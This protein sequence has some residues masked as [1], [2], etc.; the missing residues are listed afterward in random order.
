MAAVAGQQEQ[1]TVEQFSGPAERDHAL[2]EDTSRLL[3]T[4]D[5]AYEGVQG[6]QGVHGLQAIAGL[7]GFEEFQGLTS[8]GP[9]ALARLA[10]RGIRVRAL[11]PRTL[12][13]VPEHAR[14][15]RELS[16]VG[17]TVRVADHVAHDMLVFDGVTV[18]LPGCVGDFSESMIRVRGALLAR[19]FA[20]IYE[21]YWQRAT[22]LSRASARPH[23]AGMSAQERAVVRL[24]TN[25]Y[26]DDR[27]ARKLG[28]DTEVVQDVMTSLM[29]RLGAGSRFEVGYKLARELDPRDL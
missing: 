26:S 20:T 13:S 4:L 10:Q 29:Q 2:R 3:D 9:E 1:V 18:C 5:A 28:I 23:H 19:S 8:A 16:D 14:G 25:G 17:V 22:P 15:L 7:E 6:F 21:S 24:M 11:F 27:I 12:L